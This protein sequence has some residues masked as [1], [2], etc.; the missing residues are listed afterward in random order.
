MA[1][2][3]NIFA[4]IASNNRIAFI[5]ASSVIALG[6]AASSVTMAH[7]MVAMKRADREVTVLIAEATSKS[8]QIRGEGDAQRNQIFAD[9][10]GRDPDFFA[11][12]RSLIAYET[13]IKQGTPF[14][15]SPDSDFFK[16]LRSSNPR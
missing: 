10:F 16:Y 4:A 14:V 13:A 8:E 5:C 2:R 6:I 9:A 3:R 12:Y 7:G 11:F 15:I 1:R